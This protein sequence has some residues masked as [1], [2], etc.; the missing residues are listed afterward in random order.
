MAWRGVA[1]TGYYFYRFTRRKRVV[2]VGGGFA[3]S[4]VAKNLQRF[5]NVVLIDRKPHFECI[6]SLPFLVGN[7]RRAAGIQVPHS[8]VRATVSMSTSM[9]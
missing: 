5:F 4:I 8:S 2:V 3:G 9:Y 7:A 1:C 6:P